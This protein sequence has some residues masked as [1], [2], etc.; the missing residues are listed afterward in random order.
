[1]PYMRRPCCRGEK[2]VPYI[3]FSTLIPFSLFSD[4]EGS[5]IQENHQIL[6]TTSL[7]DLLFIHFFS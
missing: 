7:Y 5:F 3:W 6:S 1:M 2:K 4:S